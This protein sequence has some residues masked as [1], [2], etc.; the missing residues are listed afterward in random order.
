MVD[1]T[2]MILLLPEFFYTRIAEES[3]VFMMDW[4]PHT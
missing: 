2:S 1:T 3:Q 4:I